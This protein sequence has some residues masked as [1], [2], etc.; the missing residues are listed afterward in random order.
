MEV[1]D[2]RRH[3]LKGSTPVFVSEHNN[4]AGGCEPSC[5]LVQYV[6]HDAIKLLLCSIQQSAALAL[7]RMA[8]YSDDLAEAVVSS[9]VL[10]QLVRFQQSFAIQLQSINLW[11]MCQFTRMP[12]PPSFSY[13]G[14]VPQ[15]GSPCL[16]E[17]VWGL[18]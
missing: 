18:S 16:D 2:P 13:L 9:E 6:L 10:P 17:I 11:G 1:T 15:Q 12:F 5:I 7:G 14:T 8:N 4:L 3:L